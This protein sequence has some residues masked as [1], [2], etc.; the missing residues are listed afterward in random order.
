MTEL[1][2]ESKKN[3]TL[4]LIRSLKEKKYRRETGL[5][6]VE[7]QTLFSEALSAGL[8]PQTVV[9]SRAAGEK[10]AARV[11]RALEKTEVRL[12]V[13]SELLYATVSAEHAPQG[14]LAVFSVSDV[15]ESSKKIH[16]SVTTVAERYII[17]EK[18]RDPLNVGAILRSA[19]AFGYRGA[20]LVDSADL[21]NPKT[22]RACMGALFHLELYFCED[23]PEALEFVR[24]RAL[25]LYGTSPHAVRTIREADYGRPFA[26]LFGNEG[27]GATEEALSAC[28]EVLTIPMQGMESLNAA[29]ACAVALYES[30]RED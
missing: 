13:V 24:S 27:A 21:F 9:L 4:S 28:D 16:S 19:A 11:R 15:L 5:F 18:I 22:V 17:L 3:E 6:F 29:A 1:V 25:A 8:V 7:G 23:T 14:V 12:L 30:V 10:L 26:L 20:V 2:I